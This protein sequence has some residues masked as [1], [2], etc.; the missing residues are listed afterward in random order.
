MVIAGV[1]VPSADLHAITQAYLNHKIRFFPAALNTNHRLDAILHQIKGADLR[2]YV[3]GASRRQRTHAIGFLDGIISI[4]QY[5]QA[6]ILGRVWI[7]QIGVMHSD[8]AIYTYSLQ[9]ICTTFQHFLSS[10]NSQG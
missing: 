4:L 3:R 1:V 7:K 5:Y 6:K 10:C 9:H 2:S 8:R